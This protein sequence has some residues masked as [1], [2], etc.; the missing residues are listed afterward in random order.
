ML[1][2]GLFRPRDGLWPA[3]ST[4]PLSVDPITS[5]RAEDS[6]IHTL[7]LKNNN[8][9]MSRQPSPIA[10]LATCPSPFYDQSTLLSSLFLRSP[11]TTYD[12]WSS[13]PQLRPRYNARFCPYLH[14][15]LTLFVAYLF[16]SSYKLLS[17]TVQSKIFF[18]PFSRVLSPAAERLTTA[19]PPPS[20]F[21][22]IFSSFRTHARTIGL[23]YTT[24]TDMTKIHQKLVPIV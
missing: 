14:L 18:F 9:R 23:P 10:E 4:R 11:R 13:R 8:A 3:K 12:A 21:D 1:G 19:N 22:L 16:L 5:P 20:Y 2:I 6:W 7:R 17:P 24:S 15:P